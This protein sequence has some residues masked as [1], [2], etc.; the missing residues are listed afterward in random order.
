MRLAHR[1]K[2]DAVYLDR[3]RGVQSGR[4][5]VYGTVI[6]M[7]QEAGDRVIRQR[8]A[9]TFYKKIARIRLRHLWWTRGSTTSV[10]SGFV[11][12]LIYNNRLVVSE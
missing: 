8:G 11:E 3:Q 12:V 7:V 1:R 9:V 5:V 10:Q 6:D 2:M 4:L